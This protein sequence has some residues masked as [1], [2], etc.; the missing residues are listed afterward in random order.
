MIVASLSF[1]WDELFVNRVEVGENY[2]NFIARL[3]RNSQQKVHRAHL[4]NTRKLLAEKK[5]L[6]LKIAGLRASVLHSAM[7]G[8]GRADEPK[9]FG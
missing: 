4:D 2:M 3:H 7:Q 5:A 6:A 9:F 8:A 1:V